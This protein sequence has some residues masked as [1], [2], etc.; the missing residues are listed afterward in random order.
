MAAH[1]IEIHR[2]S[3][4]AAPRLSATGFGWNQLSPMS[5]AVNL[6]ADGCWIDGEPNCAA[7]CTEPAIAWASFYTQM[8]C[9]MYPMVSGLIASNGLAS[10]GVDVAASF[11]IYHSRLVDLS[12]IQATINDCAEAFC[13]T[14]SEEGPGAG[15]FHGFMSGSVM[16][17]TAVAYV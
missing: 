9:L 15:C 6:F 11:G 8:N 10:E 16:P 17:Q 7:A 3:T 4:D 5:T 14:R 2:V 12:L 1:L 13:K